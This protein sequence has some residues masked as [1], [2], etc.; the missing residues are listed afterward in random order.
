M[1][2]GL[3]RSREGN[4]N[5]LQYSCLGNP[6]NRGAWWAIV[7][8]SQRARHDLATKL[9]PKKKN[10]KL[11]PKRVIIKISPLRFSKWEDDEV[12]FLSSFKVK[13][14]VFLVVFRSRWAKTAC[15]GCPPPRLG[16]PAT[17]SWVTHSHVGLLHFLE[18]TRRGLPLPVGHR[19]CS[20]FCLLKCH[21]PS[22]ACPEPSSPHTV[23]AAFG[24]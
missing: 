10:D 4:G 15:P 1:I 16:P 12:S 14:R 5:P 8:G 6:M 21:L 20:H 22:E 2:P 13:P 24:P 17:S 23:P 11:P 18:N 7:M 3:G 19:A 9:R